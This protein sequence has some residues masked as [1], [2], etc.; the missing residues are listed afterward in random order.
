VYHLLDHTADIGITIEE[1]SLQQLFVSAAEAMVQLMVAFKK[2]PVSVIEVPCSLTS[3]SLD[4]LMIR[5]LSELLFLFETK[6]LLFSRIVFDALHQKELKG[7]LF[8][9][10]FDPNQHEQKLV[11]KAV[12]YH[13]L[14]VLQDKSGIWKASIIF[15]I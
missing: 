7:T 11:I 14:E 5:W 2:P 6:Q 13:K 12:T 3:Q 1:Q 15:D 4:Q 8:G 9:F 10:P